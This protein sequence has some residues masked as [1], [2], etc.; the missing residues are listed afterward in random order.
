MASTTMSSTISRSGRVSAEP[1]LPVCLRRHLTP[2]A[3][4]ECLGTER[5]GLL[6][7]DGLS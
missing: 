7:V 5:R 3:V 1:L 6:L 4:A 2:S